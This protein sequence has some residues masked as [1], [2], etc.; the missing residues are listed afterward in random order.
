MATTLQNWLILRNTVASTFPLL[1]VQQTASQSLTSGTDTLITM[2]TVNVDNYSGYSTGTSTYTCQLAGWYW[3]TAA[4][5][6]AANTTGIRNAEVWKN[7][8]S[9]AQLYMSTVA[10][11]SATVASVSGLLSL[12]SG[13]T[14]TMRGQQTSGGALS[15]QVGSG[16]NSWLS[17]EWMRET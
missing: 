3:V 17:L 2:T 11:T 16:Y 8:A 6:Y 9:V 13:D 4:V 7:G 10:S 12:A 1:K 14:V 15:T 5:V